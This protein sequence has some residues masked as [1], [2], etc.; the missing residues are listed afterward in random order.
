MRYVSPH[1]ISLASMIIVTWYVLLCRR[2]TSRGER[3]MPSENHNPLLP[4]VYSSVL[5]S[6][7]SLVCVVK[8]FLTIR[9]TLIG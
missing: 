4:L 7:C 1:S 8:R 2:D 3:Y 6:M 9:P 5:S